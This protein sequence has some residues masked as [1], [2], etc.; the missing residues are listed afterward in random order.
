M[1]REEAAEFFN[2]TTAGGVIT[3]VS[4]LFMSLLFFSELREFLALTVAV[5][6]LQ[7]AIA[8]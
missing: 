2:R 3:L 7:Q 6:G 5:F 4:A 8:F 1:Q